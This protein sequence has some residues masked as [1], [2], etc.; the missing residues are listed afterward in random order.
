VIVAAPAALSSE[1]TI[2][3]L[4][5]VLA[6]VFVA[7]KVL[8]EL[9]VRFKQPAVLGEIIAGVLLGGSALG[10]LDPHQPTI[11]AMSELGV[12]VL[13]FATG[14]HTDVGSLVKAGAA[15]MVVAVAGVVLP[16]VSG[17]YVTVALG[18]TPG[19]ALVAGAA[20]CATSIGI[21]ARVLSD[22]GQL[23]TAEGQIVLGGAVIDDVIGLIILAVVMGVTSGQSVG[24]LDIAR[25]AGVAIGF[26]AV[27]VLL[28]GKVA[29]IGHRFVKNA[30][31]TGALGIFGLAFAFAMAALAEKVGSALIV[32]AFAAGLVLDDRHDRH[33]IEKATTSIGNFVIP[34]F[35]A[36]VGAMVDLGA[37]MNAKS[38][39]IGGAL[40]VCGILGKVAAG[41]APVWFKGRKLLIGVA[42]VPRG[43]VGLI[44]AQMGLA[45]GAI[46]AGLFG[47]IMMMVL[48]TTLV[49]P[50][51]LATIARRPSPSL[52]HS[53]TP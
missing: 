38:L 13:L 15:S 47:A 35:F 39:T 52:R 48:V 10:I 26:V 40:I 43:E 37:M 20:M 7:T 51:M 41:W 46:D 6:V 8:G 18:S 50:P 44:F 22:L 16:F 17:Y 19:Q 5:L 21:S 49:T 23:N 31:V 24:P 42:M 4:L 32:G 2:G 11:H 25:I 14:L 33:E 34:I 1:M 28:G 12:I 9:A 3:Q 45:A 36:S 27:A 30:Q 29:S 53:T